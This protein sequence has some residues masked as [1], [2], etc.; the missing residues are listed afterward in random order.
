[1]KKVGDHYE[2]IAAYVDDMLVFAREPMKV[3]KE[4]KHDYILK[5]VGKPVYYLSS[6]VQELGVMWENNGSTTAILA[7]TYICNVVKKFE[8]IFGPIQEFKSPMELNYHPELDLTPLMDAKHASLYRALIGSANW[9]ITLGRFNIHYA[10]NALSQFA[11]ALQ[12]GHLEAMKQVFGY[13]KKYHKGRI[14]I[15][16]NWMDWTK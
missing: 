16:P 14:I 15:D 4:L 2:Y 5:G 1:M 13:L 7:E 6:D 3:I 10:T 8:G 9:L 11:M 12:E